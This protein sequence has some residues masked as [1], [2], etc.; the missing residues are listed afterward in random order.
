M[1]YFITTP[2]CGFSHWQPHDL[3]LAVSLWGEPEV[4]KYICASGVFTPEEIENRLYT[5][6]RNFEKY[7]LQYFPVYALDNGELVGCCG[8]RPYKNQ[9]GIFELGFHMRKD[10]WHRGYATECASAVIEYAF[11][12]LGA[13]ELKA[14]HNPNNLASKKVLSKLGFQYEAEEFYEPTG[15][16]HPRYS[17]KLESKR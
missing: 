14:G 7:G 4:T 12:A 15:L 10:Y 11:S 3:S 2:R 17:C 16:Y 9:A 1:D 6:I 5:E 13:T 8:L